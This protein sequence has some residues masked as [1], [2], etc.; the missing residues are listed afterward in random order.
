MHTYR[1]ISQMPGFVLVYVFGQET[2]KSFREICLF[3]F[4]TLKNTQE[5]FLFDF[6]EWKTEQTHNFLKKMLPP[7]LFLSNNRARLPLGFQG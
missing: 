6:I 7:D 1:F 2:Q 4:V 5:L 3:V